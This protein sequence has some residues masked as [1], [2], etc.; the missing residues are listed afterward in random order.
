VEWRRAW[1]IGV[2]AAAVLVFG[3]MAVV[4]IRPT[5]APSYS[6][7]PPDSGAMPSAPAAAAVTLQP[8]PSGA[9]VVALG[10]SWAQATGATSPDKGWLQ[11]TARHFGWSLTVVPDGGG[12]GYLTPGPNNAGTYPQR[13]AKQPVDRSV[14]LVIVEGGVNDATLP[15]VDHAD[16]AI[17]RTFREAR[18]KYPQAQLLAVAEVSTAPIPWPGLVTISDEIAHEAAVASPPVPVIVPIQDHWLGGRF[19]HR[20][21]PLNGHPT[22]HGYAVLSHL[23]EHAV[24]GLEG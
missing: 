13:L 9:K 3:Y 8:V 4:L 2:L 18:A 12:T 19:M 6:P 11:L 15:K 14:D 22:D 5:P 1:N 24:S 7:P 16:P 21:G 10:D 20:G 17:A 23:L